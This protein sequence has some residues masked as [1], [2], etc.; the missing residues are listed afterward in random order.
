MVYGVAIS[1]KKTMAHKFKP[2][3]IVILGKHKGCY[4]Y[5]DAT[6]DSYVGKHAILDRPNEA[7]PPCYSW[8]VRMIDGSHVGLYFHENAMQIV[9]CQCQIKNCLTHHPSRIKHGS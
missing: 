7:R 1:R 3:S 8:Y 4:C 9:G 6:M 5:W 2:G